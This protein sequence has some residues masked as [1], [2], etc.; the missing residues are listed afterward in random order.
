MLECTEH[1]LYSS[2]GILNS[3]LSCFNNL[4][5]IEVWLLAR[6]SWTKALQNVHFCRTM[7]QVHNDGSAPL[8]IVDRRTQWV[9]LSATIN[10]RSII[11]A[12]QSRHCV[13][14]APLALCVDNVCVSSSMTMRSASDVDATV[15]STCVLNANKAQTPVSAIGRDGWAAG[16]SCEHGRKADVGKRVTV[17]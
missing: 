7:L 9:S 11:R 3:V 16:S 17:L 14:A 15:K 4:F 1:C 8:P 5:V 10:I 13:P 2:Q 6:G 12:M